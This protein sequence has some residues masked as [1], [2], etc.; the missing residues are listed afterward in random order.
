MNIWLFKLTL[1]IGYFKEKWANI[2][3]H[4]KKIPPKNFIFIF[5]HWKIN[6]EIPFWIKQLESFFFLLF[7]NNK[8]KFFF[9]LGY[10]LVLL[11]SSKRII[12]LK[13][14]QSIHYTSLDEKVGDFN[15][16]SMCGNGHIKGVKV[17]V[18]F[19]EVNSS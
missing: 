1:V 14:A 16:T 10:L 5:S 6:H 17:W 13:N 15:A 9:S 3:K 12:Q 4:S 7:G 2:V 18:F 8:W 11:L 19:F